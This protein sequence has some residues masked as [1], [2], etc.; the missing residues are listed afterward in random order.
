MFRVSDAPLFI[1]PSSASP[2]FW[3]TFFGFGENAHFFEFDF[4]SSCVRLLKLSA[5]HDR[6]EPE[7]FVAG[8][9]LSWDPGVWKRRPAV[10]ETMFWLDAW[11]N[12]WSEATEF[13]RFLRRFL[14]FVSE[15]A[16]GVKG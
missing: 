6:K 4:R 13:G 5:L 7:P 2:L 3:E 8:G 16:S 1:P 12:A 11:S 9:I 14:L 15:I 10:L